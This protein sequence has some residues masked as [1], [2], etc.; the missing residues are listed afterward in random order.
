MDSWGQVG[1]VG[2]SIL[3]FG[4]AQLARLLDSKERS[5]IWMAPTD[6]DALIEH[7]CQLKG[8]SR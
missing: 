8:H 1:Q 2:P 4:W 5:I 7:G 6:R 3:F